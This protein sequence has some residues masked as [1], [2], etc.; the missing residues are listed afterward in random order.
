MTAAAPTL[1]P[2]CDIWP[3]TRALL[4][5]ADGRAVVLAR[6]NVL[7][8]PGVV[9][10]VA[11]SLVPAGQ[12]AWLTAAEFRH[13]GGRPRLRRLRQV[14]EGAGTWDAAAAAFI[15]AW[16]ARTPVSP[17]PPRKKPEGGLE[18]E[19]IGPGEDL[20]EVAPLKIPPYLRPRRAR[21]ARRRATQ[22]PA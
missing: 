20:K 9:E 2:P 3:Q 18:A 10:A 8:A 5:L 14:I 16:M 21:T 4:L 17:L 19:A 7:L 11:A 22:T 12:A 13:P 15:G 6:G 1:S